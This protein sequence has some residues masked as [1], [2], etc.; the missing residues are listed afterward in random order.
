MVQRNKGLSEK[1]LKE[2]T[3]KSSSIPTG[4]DSIQGAKEREEAEL[5]Q[6]IEESMALEVN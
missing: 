6:A 1:A 3:K 2:I 5:K 4:Q